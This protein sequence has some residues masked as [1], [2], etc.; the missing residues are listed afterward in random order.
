MSSAL[1]PFLSIDP[2][3]WAAPDLLGARSPEPAE[4]PSPRA[5]EVAVEQAAA[6]AH[7]DALIRAARD[8]AQVL[9]ESARGEADTLRAQAREQ[10]AAEAHTE[11]A[12]ERERLA[13][14]LQAAYAELNAERERFMREA[15]PEM[16]KL[17]LAVAEK[18]I[19]REV[20]THPEIVLDLIRRSLKRL[21]DKSELRVRVNPD[22]LQAVREARADLLAAVDGIEKLELADDR[23]VGRG[24]CVIESPNGAI[25]A[26]ISTQLHELERSIAQ[27][28]PHEPHGD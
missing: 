9:I 12:T 27:V 21:K 8:E 2:R 5:A 23:R 26:R 13:A 22:D 19:G 1:R 15:E 28:T 7:A 3:A 16:L 17:S 11:T 10:G 24:G 4:A 14:E 6:A 25:D 20:S 18:V